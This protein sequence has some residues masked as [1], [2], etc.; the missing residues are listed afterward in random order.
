[1][2]ILLLRHG[3]TDWNLQ[4]RCQGAT[5]RHLNDSGLR[6]AQ[7]VARNLRREPI[8]AIYS[9]NLKRAIQT[10]DLVGHYHKELPVIVE[11]DFRELDH[12]HLEGLTFDEI[13]ERYPQFLAH[14]R[15]TPANL[16][17]PGGESLAEL[18]QRSWDALQRVA[19]RHATG[20]AL[21]VTH[22]FPI[23]SI[24]CRVTGTHLNSYR[25]F[26]TRPC[27]LVRIH[28]ESKQGWRLAQLRQD[29]SE[30]EAGNDK[31]P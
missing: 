16:K 11:G 28:Y 4:G 6:Q 18:D 23:L 7:E 2:E 19:R 15:S 3:E 9:S 31:L 30:T 27:A 17:I 22:N 12:G 24:L 8:T 10:A 5:D 29:H 26:R 20:T 21:V 1:M 13:K 25:N 14:W